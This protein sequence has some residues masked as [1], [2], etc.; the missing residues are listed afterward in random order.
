MSAFQILGENAL[1]DTFVD[2]E[3]VCYRVPLWHSGVFGH[4]HTPP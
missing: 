1:H 4:N 3:L 2:F